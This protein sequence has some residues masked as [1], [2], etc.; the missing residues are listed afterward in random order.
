MRKCLLRFLAHGGRCSVDEIPSFLSSFSA[1]N[2]VAGAGSGLWMTN[3][4]RLESN[5]HCWLIN[6]VCPFTSQ[7]NRAVNFFLDQHSPLLWRKCLSVPFQLI[8]PSRKGVRALLEW[9]SGA[10]Q[11]RM[12]GAAGEVALKGSSHQFS[13]R[14]AVVSLGHRQKGSPLS[15]VLT[16]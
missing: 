12:C 10:S 13:S 8:D 1:F 15:L 3:H 7:V 6:V 4:C 2:C 9:D 14:I 5:G 16:F 11:R